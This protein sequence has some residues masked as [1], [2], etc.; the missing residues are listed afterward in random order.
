MYQRS[1]LSD[2]EPPNL[3]LGPLISTALVQSTVDKVLLTSYYSVV[4]WRN[5][6]IEIF[7]LT[8]LGDGDEDEIRP[9]SR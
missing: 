3:F 1:H 9:R 5:Y 7:Q 8:W 2:A 6:F 4:D